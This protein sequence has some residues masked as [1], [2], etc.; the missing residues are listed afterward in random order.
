ME[1]SI[2]H[3]EETIGSAQIVREGLFWCVSAKILQ[4]K[5]ELF[6]LYAVYQWK[7]EYLGVFDAAGALNRRI[8]VSHLPQGIT[9][10]LAT[11]CPR[12]QWLPWRGELDGIAVAD[13]FLLAQG[14]GLRLA[15]GA[16]EMLK[17]PLWLAQMKNETVYDRQMA[18]LTLGA[19]GALPLIERESR[20]TE[21]ETMDPDAPDCEL[22]AFTPADDG[23]GA[24]DDL[25]DAAAGGAPD[26]GGGEKADCPDL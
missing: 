23:S 18:V 2:F 7:V 10:L 25:V 4:K 14:G 8:A 12:G 1:L 17:F 19:E 20:G 15:L 3:A 26:E 11:T 22:S 21:D 9:F 24:G 6:R 16:G 5:R 13:A